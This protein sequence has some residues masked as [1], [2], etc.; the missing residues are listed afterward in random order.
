MKVEDEGLTD[1]QECGTLPTL[2][3]IG[4]REFRWFGGHQSGDPERCC[5][6]EF[7]ETGGARRKLNATV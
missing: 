6:C 3:T 7:W 5:A 4:R 1:R 2:E